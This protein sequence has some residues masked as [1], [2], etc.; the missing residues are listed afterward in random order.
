MSTISNVVQAL[1]CWTASS[2][3]ASSHLWEL[4]SNDVDPDEVAEGNH[5]IRWRG[6]R[7]RSAGFGDW[8]LA[9]FTEQWT[10]CSGARGVQRGAA[11]GK[12]RR[13]SEGACGGGRGQPEGVLQEYQFIVGWV[14]DQL[15]GVGESCHRGI[16]STPTSWPWNHWGLFHC[17]LFNKKSFEQPTIL[18][19]RCSP[20]LLGYRSFA[21]SPTEILERYFILTAAAHSTAANCFQW[22]L[23]NNCVLAKVSRCCKYLHAATSNPILWQGLLFS[24]VNR[25][26]TCDNATPCK[27]V[28]KV[29]LDALAM[30]PT[31]SRVSLHFVP[32]Q[33]SWQCA[34]SER[35]LDTHKNCDDQ[36]WR[37]FWSQVTK[38]DFS[39]AD[40]LGTVQLEQIC[41]LSLRGFL[42]VFC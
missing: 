17:N 9:G 16:D 38:L 23:S 35:F 15:L 3:R 25:L 20:I 30:F 18:L 27:S 39:E 41:R 28:K 31:I 34:A 42:Q 2:P 24:Q 40:N 11:A 13:P 33:T 14:G 32:Y 6:G 1:P 19:L 21:F 4:L 12:P 36:D 29:W 7:H 8:G 5:C 10:L 22:Y 26:H 37:Q